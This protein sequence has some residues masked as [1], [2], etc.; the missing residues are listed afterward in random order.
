M[1]S[2]EGEEV[3]AAGVDDYVAGGAEPNVCA[4]LLEKG[5]CNWIGEKVGLADV[6]TVGGEGVGDY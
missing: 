3:A 5:C 1:G 4:G 2:A 6:G